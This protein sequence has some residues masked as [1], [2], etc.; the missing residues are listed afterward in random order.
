[1]PEYE[2]QGPGGGKHHQLKILNNRP[3]GAAAAK[4]QSYGSSDQETG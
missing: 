1:M 3:Q 4:D 2:G